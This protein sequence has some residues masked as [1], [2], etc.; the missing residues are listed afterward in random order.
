MY[1]ILRVQIMNINYIVQT[2][3]SVAESEEN[4]SVRGGLVD[5]FTVS[6]FLYSNICRFCHHQNKFLLLR[7]GQNCHRSPNSGLVVGMEAGTEYVN[8]TN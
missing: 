8:V 6:R 7:L 5:I 3:K 1:A 2:E 4:Y